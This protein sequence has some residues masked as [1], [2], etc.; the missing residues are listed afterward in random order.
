FLITLPLAA[1]AC[2]FFWEMWNYYALPK[3]KYDLPFLNW[4]PHIFEMPLPGWLGYLPFG[5]E[6]FAMYQFT[7]WLCRLRADKLV[8]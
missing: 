8:F 2:G 7:L 3:W 4:A 1:I 6:L 5:L